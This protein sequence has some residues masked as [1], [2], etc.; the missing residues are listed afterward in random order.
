[1][2][3]MTLTGVASF[4]HAVR[5]AGTWLAD[6]A[7]A[8]GEE[9]NHDRAYRLLRAWLHTLRDR[10]PV[11]VTVH[12][13]AQLPTLIRGVF[14]EGWVPHAVPAKYDRAEFLS[15]FCREAHLSGDDAETAE[16]TVRAISGAL[17]HHLS[18]G[19][20]D[21]VLGSLPG[22]VRSILS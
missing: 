9:E 15:R 8:T 6:V 10:L 12:L 4:D 1:V 21:R 3:I 11:D 7:K 19:T 20:L 2:L 17:D 13:G 16:D 5:S 18:P 22:A 14:Y